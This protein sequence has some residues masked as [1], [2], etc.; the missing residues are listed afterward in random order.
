VYEEAHGANLLVLPSG[1]LMCAWFTGNEGKNGVGIVL[2]RLHPG[3]GQWTEPQLVDFGLEFGKAVRG[4][5]E[6]CG[7][8]VAS[9]GGEQRSVATPQAARGWARPPCRH[10]KI[11]S[12]YCLGPAFRGGGFPNLVCWIGLAGAARVAPGGSKAHQSTLPLPLSRSLYLYLSLSLSLYLYL[13]LSLSIFG[14]VCSPAACARSCKTPC[15]TT[16][17]APTR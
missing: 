4:Q 17:R 9:A 10:F 13:P 11:Q 8:A 6:A 3:A 14:P 5:G 1:E 7:T 15:C 12:C 16:R 2:S